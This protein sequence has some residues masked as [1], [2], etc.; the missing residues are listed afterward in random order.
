MAPI[1]IK[2]AQKIM[3]LENLISQI[4]NR[5]KIFKFFNVGKESQATNSPAKMVRQMSL[6]VNLISA[7]FILR[8]A[9]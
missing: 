4:V 3:K 8:S 6:F 7:I 5:S 1:G 9:Y 2:R